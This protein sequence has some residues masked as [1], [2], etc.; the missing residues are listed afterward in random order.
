MKDLEP[1][2]PTYVED[3]LSRRPFVPIAGVINVRDLGGYPSDIHPGKCTKPGFIYRSAEVAGITEEGKEQVRSLGI[4]KIFDLRSDTEIEKYNSPLPTIEGVELVHAPVFQT[5]DYSPEMMARRYKLYASGKTEAF[6]EL[7]S[8]ILDHGGPAFG[9]I[10]L[11]VRDHPN[12]AFMFHCTAGKDRTGI[13]AAILLKLAG[14]D[15]DV[16]SDDYA[17]TRIGREPAREKIMERLS[18]EPLFASN[19][20]AALNMF[21][22]RRETMM[23]FLDLLQDKYGGVQEY[24]K[25]FIHLSDSDITTIQN[26]ILVSSS[27]SHL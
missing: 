1:L 24:L 21:T 3:V 9:A 25:Q 7:Y 5:E 20:E 14:V 19:N 12:D 15:N 11:F 4:K 17:L 18:K 16:I 8:Q 22:C 13:I 23:A 2:D 10:L 26:N 6:M 27:D